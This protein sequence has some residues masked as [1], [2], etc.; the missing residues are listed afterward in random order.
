[1]HELEPRVNAL[2]KLHQ[3]NSVTLREV[4]TD[5]HHM[6]KTLDKIEQTLSQFADVFAKVDEVGRASARAHSRID[7][8]ET[9]YRA[10]AGEFVACK[11]TKLSRDDIRELQEHIENVDKKVTTL[12]VSLAEDSWRG[13]LFDRFVMMAVGALGSGVGVY[14]L[15]GGAGG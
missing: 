15:S 2:E 4:Q 11:A 3:D 12:E 14:L 5:F 13:R 6:T 8:L 10:T 1:M 7:R 9:E